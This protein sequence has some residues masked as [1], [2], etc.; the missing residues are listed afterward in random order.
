[1]DKSELIKKIK[2]LGPWH[3][4]IEVEEGIFTEINKPNPRGKWKVMESFLPEDLTGKTVLDLGGNEGF[5][6]IQMKKRGA[7]KVVLK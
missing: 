6:S 7:S 1:M 2:D 3:H 4:R 5:Y